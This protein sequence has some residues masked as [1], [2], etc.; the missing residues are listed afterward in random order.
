MLLQI[1]KL[2]LFFSS[3]WK[4]EEFSSNIYCENLVDLLD[5]N[6]VIEKCGCD[7]KECIPL[8]V[9]TLRHVHTEPPQLINYSLILPYPDVVPME[10]AVLVTS[11]S[12]C[13]PLSS[14]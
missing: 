14:I 4:H 11:N 7:L 6:I 9:L 5:V 8:E 2:S 1:S 3:Y 10:I 13:L 12:I